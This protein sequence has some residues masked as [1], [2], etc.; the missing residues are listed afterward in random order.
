MDLCCYRKIRMVYQPRIQRDLFL[1]N[2]FRN[3]KIRSQLRLTVRGRW[4]AA[5]NRSTIIVIIMI[6][7]SDGAGNS[8]SSHN[9]ND[10]NNTLV[11]YL[12]LVSYFLAR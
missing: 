5:R 8:H 2:F 9:I 7:G 11:D 4:W 1:C 6:D 12:F 10:I 3:N